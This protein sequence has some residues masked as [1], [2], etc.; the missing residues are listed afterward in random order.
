MK[1]FGAAPAVLAQLSAPTSS[2]MML[3]WR[4]VMYRSV[5]KQRAGTAFRPYTA[6]KLVD[7]SQTSH[8]KSFPWDVRKLDDTAQLEARHDTHRV[9]PLGGALGALPE[10]TVCW[11]A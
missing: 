11:T 1:V 2:L 5:C 9:A 10:G 8:E 7:W 4:L 6:Q 3:T